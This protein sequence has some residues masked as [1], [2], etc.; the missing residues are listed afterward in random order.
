MSTE[1][2]YVRGWDWHADWTWLWPC[3]RCCREFWVSDYLFPIPLA[4]PPE[5]CIRASAELC[6]AYPVET[7]KKKSAGCSVGLYAAFQLSSQ[8]RRVKGNAEAL[9]GLLFAPPPPLFPALESGGVNRSRAS[10]RVTGGDHVLVR[11]VVELSSPSKV[12]RL[13]LD[14]SIGRSVVGHLTFRCLPPAWLGFDPACILHLPHTFCSLLRKKKTP[15][16]RKIPSE[17]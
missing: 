8:S 17:R 7:R 13:L 10:L 11:G 16:A 2:P 3:Y 6:L 14:V 5:I 9:A 4:F 1:W 15:Y 12:I